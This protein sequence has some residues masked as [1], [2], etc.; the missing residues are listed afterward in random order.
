ML[1]FIFAAFI[2]LKF[3]LGKK[4]NHLGADYMRQCN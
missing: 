2:K 4:T 3:C 1:A